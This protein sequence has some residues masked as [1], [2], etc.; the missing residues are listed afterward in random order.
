MA[1]AGGLA[2]NEAS[3]RLT[4]TGLDIDCGAGRF[5]VRIRGLLLFLVLLQSLFELL[6]LL[7]E[8][9]ELLAHQLHVAVTGGIHRKSGA[10]DR[11]AKD[12]LL[13]HESPQGCRLRVPYTLAYNSST[14][15]L[16]L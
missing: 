15:I 2:V 1:S 10:R 8:C 12:K 13:F 6:N 5:G 3:A 9:I 16:L 11:E 7:L 14:G 4:G